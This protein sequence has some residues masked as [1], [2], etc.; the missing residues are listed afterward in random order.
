MDNLTP[1]TKWAEKVLARYPEQLSIPEQAE[2]EQHLQTCSECTDASANHALAALCLRSLPPVKRSSPPT[3]QQLLRGKMNGLDQ[4]VE[5]AGS[6]REYAYAKSGSGI[7][8]NGNNGEVEIARSKREY[9]YTKSG[10]GIV[11]NGNNGKET[12][13]A[14]A[15]KPSKLHFPQPLTSLIGREQETA[16]VAALLQRSDVHL[17]NIVGTAGVGKTRLA[18]QV[19]TDLMESFVDGAFFVSLASLRHAELVLPTIAQTLGLRVKRGQSVLDLLGTTLRD[20]HC[21]LLLDNCEQVVSAM[22]LL[23]ELLQAC[24]FVKMLVTSRTVLH[25]RGEYTFLV[26]PLALP[27]LT[28]KQDCVS[29]SLVAAVQCFLDRVQAVRPSFQLTDS[30]AREVAEICIR[31]D[32]LP[33]ALELAATY[34]NLLSPQQLLSRLEHRLDLLTDGAADL[35]ERQQTLRK[36]LQWSYELLNKEEQQLFR[37]LSVCVGGCT[38]EG[39]E[40]IYNQLGESGDQ[41][42]SGITGLLDKQLLYQLQ[43][44]EGRLLMLETIREYGLECLATCG[45]TEAIHSAHAR[46]YLAQAEQSASKESRTGQELVWL[47]HEHDNLRAALNWFLEHN[48]SHKASHMR[49]ALCEKR[50]LPPSQ[51]APSLGQPHPHTLPEGEGLTPCEL[52]V[53]RLLA[54]G[55]RSAEIA[56]QL[57]ISIT[58]VNSHLRS[59]YSKL[60]VTS[61]AAATRYAI[62]HHLV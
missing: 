45:E 23:V 35:P 9:A 62:E 36:T 3:L 15:H 33:L 57:V 26:H 14:E 5:I 19:S 2:L 51:E 47:K 39:V 6:K 12:N 30:M 40:G 8:E 46:Y 38:L 11:E 13:N 25:V 31:L 56:E 16:A 41:L 34:L 10:S 22:P 17:V 44:G 1:C 32:G 37:R 50:T 28:R 48:E 7:V 61:R 18:L 42:L 58:T 55:L 21:L 54:Q 20:K 24:P 53:L 59:I 43:Q 29:L 60:G 52:K 27:D 4:E 49:I